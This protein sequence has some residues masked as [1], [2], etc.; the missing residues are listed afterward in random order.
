MSPAVLY[1][2]SLEYSRS[3]LHPQPIPFDPVVHQPPPVT[4]QTRSDLCETL[5]YFRSWF[6]NLYQTEGHIYGFLLEKHSFSSRTYIDSEVVIARFGSG[7]TT[8]RGEQILEAL[9]RTMQFGTSVV[10]IT[11]NGYR[12]LP[13]TIKGNADVQKAYSVLGHFRLVSMWE[14]LENFEPETG[15]K[16]KKAGRWGMLMFVKCELGERSWWTPNQRTPLPVAQRD[17]SVPSCRLA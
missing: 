1:Q 11:T 5:P 6:G 14:E 16:K 8:Q 13:V 17:W 9:Q 7:S 12:G 4:A 2:R 15:F 3:L 10:L